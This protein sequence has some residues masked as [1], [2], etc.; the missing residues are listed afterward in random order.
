MCFRA[1]FEQLHCDLTV[2]GKI[3]L[4]SSLLG[5]DM[6]VQSPGLITCNAIESLHIPTL[7]PEGR[8]R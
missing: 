7:L 8:N 5:F 4:R 1:I 3:V 6:Y 2:Q